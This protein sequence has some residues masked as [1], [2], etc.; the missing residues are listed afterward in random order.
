MG[1]FFVRERQRVLWGVRDAGMSPTAFEIFTTK[2][3]AEAQIKNLRYCYPWP[4]E[5]TL[6]EVRLGNW[7][8]IDG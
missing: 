8:E 7:K 4:E 3:A 2:E 6:H 1:D 5:I